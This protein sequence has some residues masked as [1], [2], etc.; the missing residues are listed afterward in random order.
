[1]KKKESH[2]LN[3][4]IVVFIANIIQ[5]LNC[6]IIVKKFSGITY[7]GKNATKCESMTQ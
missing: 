6:Q 3:A 5:N 4:V 1:M 2:R 7:S